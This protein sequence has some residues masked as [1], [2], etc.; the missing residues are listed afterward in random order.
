MAKSERRK[1]PYLLHMGSQELS[2]PGGDEEDYDSS[3][4]SHDQNQLREL[5]DSEAEEDGATPGAALL[6]GLG[7]GAGRRRN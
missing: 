3:D 5:L 6:S 4:L 2:R 1:A 7:E